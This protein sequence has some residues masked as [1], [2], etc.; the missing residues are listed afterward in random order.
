VELGG[1]TL[2]DESFLDPLGRP[3]RMQK[4]VKVY[5]RKDCGTCGGPLLGTRKSIGG[6]ASLYCPSCQR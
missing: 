1:S 6:R 2:D 4:H 3:G 5:G